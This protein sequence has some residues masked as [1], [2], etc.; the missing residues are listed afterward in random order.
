MLSSAGLVPISQ[1]LA[2]ALSK[3]DLPLLFVVPGMLVLLVT[4]RMAIHPELKRVAS[5]LTSVQAESYGSGIS[6]HSSD[7]SQG[8]AFALMLM[9]CGHLPLYNAQYMMSGA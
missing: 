2:G 4:F 5:S 3:Y 9:P 6:V 7:Y 8:P 1:A